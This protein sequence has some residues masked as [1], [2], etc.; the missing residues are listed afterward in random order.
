[1]KNLVFNVI[2]I[3]IMALGL[4]LQAAEP[5]ALQ[6]AM[7]KMQLN[8]KSI[9]LQIA[10]PSKNESSALMTKE[11]LVGVKAARLETPPIVQNMPAD[12]QDVALSHYRERLDQVIALGESLLVNLNNGDNQAASENLRQ[13]SLAKRD[14]HS[15]F[16]QH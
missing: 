1:M 4:N 5:T 11:F 7:Q 8:L 9:S 13:L 10:D 16:I 14:G 12:R 6:L 3:T 2:V 15:E